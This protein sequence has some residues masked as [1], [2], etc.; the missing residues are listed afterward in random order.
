MRFTV[1]PLIPLILVAII[2]ITLR[3]AI[4]ASGWFYWDDLLLIARSREY[5][6]P[7]PE[8]LLT[9]HDGHLMPGS[10]LLIWILAATTTG[11]SWPAAAFLNTLLNA[12]AVSAV[13][14]AAVTIA[15][16]HAWWITL[17]YVLSPLV[18]PTATWTA[19]AINSLPLHA[20]I[21]LMLRHGWLTLTTTRRRDPIIVASTV[22]VAALFSERILFAAPVAFLLVIAWVRARGLPVRRLR[23]LAA[24]TWI[25]VVSVGAAYALIVGDPRH[26][27][28]ITAPGVAEILIRGYTHGVL[29]VLAG[30][31]V[32]WERW[33][34]GP[35]F[36]GPTPILTVL[37]AI[38]AVA[39]LVRAARCTSGRGWAVGA[40][41]LCLAYPV[42]PFLAIALARTSADT[43]VEIVQTLR[44]FGEVAVLL[45]LTI[46][47]PISPNSPRE[48]GRL[49]HA[50]IAALGIW[51]AIAVAG[52]VTYLQ[53]WHP[54]PAR[55]YFT[56][57]SSELATRDQP[58]LNQAVPLEVLTPVTHP[59]NQLDHLIGAPQVESWTGEP[60]IVDATGTL[61]PATLMIL[62]GYAGTCIEGRTTIELDGPLLD[63]EW[64]VHVNYLAEHSGEF[65][66]A[67]DAGAVTV[68]VDE[69]LHQVYVQVSGGG[70][71]ITITGDGLCLGRGEVGVPGVK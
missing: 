36:A 8:F 14:T 51:C 13:A 17:I 10:W 54:Q 59:Y 34:P 12:A 38:V 49:R 50:G 5:S 21:A 39:L 15:R 53:V 23:A 27:A 67:L 24:A 11:F 63:R 18:L 32:L 1:R 64:V 35:P 60:V 28:E 52:N 56:H 7:S 4:S 62:R 29:P 46:G 3:S 43:S 69:G 22:L 19:A 57:L 55:G 31:P 30:G 6:H 33:D 9:P 65:E 16:R 42:L 20:G 37:G 61:R 48:P 40:L 26:T 58:I 2:G 71:A 66:L 70:E 25:P 45:A 44:H 68:P 47:V 41:L